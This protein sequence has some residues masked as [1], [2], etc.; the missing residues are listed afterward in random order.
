MTLELPDIEIFA[1]YAGGLRW[2]C[3][4]TLVARG[5]ISAVTASHLAGVDLLTFQDVLMQREIPRILYVGDLHVMSR[6]WKKLFSGVVVADTP[7][8]FSISAAWRSRTCTFQSSFMRSSFPRK[9]VTSLNGGANL[10]PIRG[11]TVPAWVHEQQHFRFQE[12]IS[13][14][15]IS[16]PAK[17]CCS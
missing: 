13:D 9:F 2:N 8:S 16:T 11:L 1:F 10:S 4:R 5:R 17:C 6:R 15:R 14:E 3:L 12:K 7:R